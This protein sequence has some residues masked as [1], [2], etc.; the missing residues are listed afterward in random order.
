VLVALAVVEMLELLVQLLLEQ[1]ELQ[2]LAAVVAV[3]HFK[4][5]HL[6][7]VVTVVQVL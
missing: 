2:I 5:V 6:R 3:H 4:V 1:R 7:Q